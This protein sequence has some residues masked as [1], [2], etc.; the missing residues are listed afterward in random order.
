MFPDNCEKKYVCLSDFF[1]GG[2]R[3]PF[4]FSRDTLCAFNGEDRKRSGPKRS[5]QKKEN[6][7][8]IGPC[9]SYLQNLGSPTRFP[10]RDT[11]RTR[12]DP[13]RNPGTRLADRRLR[14][15]LSHRN[16]RHSFLRKNQH[17]A[18]Y[19]RTRH[20]AWRNLRPGRYQRCL[21]PS[22]SRSRRYGDEPFAVD[23]MRRKTSHASTSAQF[24]FP[25][26]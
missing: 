22:V 26:Q 8:D 23:T 25:F 1:L 17:I 18:L 7:R 19:A 20:S 12:N 21:R 9:R 4:Y 14:S 10:A 13:N 2:Y 11:S 24:V 3:P 5:D 6:S 16:L 15:R